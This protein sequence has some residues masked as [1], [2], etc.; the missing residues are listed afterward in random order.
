[1]VM[2]DA[3]ASSARVTLV[4]RVRLVLVATRVAAAVLSVDVDPT[5][6]VF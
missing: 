5:A 3:L 1:M 6:R 2:I 4:P